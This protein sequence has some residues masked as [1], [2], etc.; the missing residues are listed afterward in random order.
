MST[1]N[2]QPPVIDPDRLTINQLRGLNCAHCAARL[3][4]ARSIGTHHIGTG[5]HADDVELYACE[6]SCAVAVE[7]QPHAWCHLC[8]DPIDAAMA[9]PIGNRPA[10]TGPGRLLYADAKCPVAYRII[11]LAEHPADTDGTIRFRTAD[12]FVPKSR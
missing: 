11:P 5:V 6:P 9:V 4:R 8:H 7:R 1:D 10:P 3:Y 12:P 2:T